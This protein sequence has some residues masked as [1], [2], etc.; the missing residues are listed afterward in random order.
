MLSQQFHAASIAATLVSILLALPSAVLAWFAYRSDRKEAAS[1]LDAKVRTLAAAVLAAE[2]AQVTQLLGRGGHRIDLTFRYFPG[3]ANNTAGAAPNG[4]LSNVRHYY[5]EL[6][7]ARLLITGEAGA[8]KTLLALQLLL[9]LLNDPL[10]SDNAPVPVRLS[11][12]GW[13]TV[14]PLHRWIAEQVTERFHDRGITLDDA[15]ALVDQRRI[16]PVLDGLDEMDPDGDTVPRRRAT[17]ALEQL[18]DYQDVEGSA[19]AIVTCRTTQYAELTAVDIRM[20]DAARVEIDPIPP[21]P[22]DH[23]RQQPHHRRP[24]VG[25][26]PYRPKHGSQRHSGPVPGHPLAAEPRGHRL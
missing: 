6:K 7:P 21:R 17:R 16:L 25:T 12:A 20:R 15:R 9:D 11:L 14:Q 10:R 1:D 26:R 2:M 24:T 13:D 5:G 8:G 23:L 19:P 22:G 4:R 3:P 18:S